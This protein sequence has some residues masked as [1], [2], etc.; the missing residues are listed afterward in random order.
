MQYGQNLMKSSATK[1]LN[2]LNWLKFHDKRC[3]ILNE[4][5]GQPKIMGILIQ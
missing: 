2:N 4:S 5:N 3:M 1:R